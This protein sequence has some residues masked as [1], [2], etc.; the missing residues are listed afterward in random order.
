MSGVFHLQHNTLPSFYLQPE[1]SSTRHEAFHFTHAAGRN[2]RVWQKRVTECGLNV[3]V[4][5]FKL[6]LWC[7]PALWLTDICWMSLP[8][9]GT[10][11][12]SRSRGFLRPFPA[13]VVNDG[14]L[15]LSS[16]V[17]WLIPYDTVGK[18]L[19]NKKMPTGFHM[20][21]AYGDRIHISHVSKSHDFPPQII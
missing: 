10:G 4:N 15:S 9:I 18:Y 14:A 16:Q 11:V 20:K 1:I 5:S 8:W 12:V 2:N 19:I 6:K 13:G 3:E 17:W 7:F 21:Y